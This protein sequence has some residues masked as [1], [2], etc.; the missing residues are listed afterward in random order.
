MKR[1]QIRVDAV[2][3]TRPTVDRSPVDPFWLGY[4]WAQKGTAFR[5]VG[6]WGMDD[7][8]GVSESDGLLGSVRSSKFK[9]PGETQYQGSSVPRRKG[10]RKNLVSSSSTHFLFWVWF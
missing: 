3:A 10:S 4:G 7:K 2:F 9:T 8:L 5:E 1:L 6:V